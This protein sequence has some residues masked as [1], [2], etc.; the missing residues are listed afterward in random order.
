MTFTV[1]GSVGTD[2]HPVPRFLDWVAVA[3]QQLGFDV[4]VERGYTDARADGPTVDF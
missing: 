1:I 2:L 4:L 3:Q